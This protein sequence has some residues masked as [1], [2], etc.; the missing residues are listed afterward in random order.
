MKKKIFLK[1]KKARKRNKKTKKNLKSKR[2]KRTS[3]KKKSPRNKMI[4]KRRLIKSVKARKIP[5]RSVRKKSARVIESKKGKSS[6]AYVGKGILEQLFESYLKVRILRFFFRNCGEVF[7]I[8]EIFRRIR[9]KNF[10]VRREIN[11]LDK[12]GLLRRKK[13]WI[14]IK[15]R[16]GRVKKEQRIVYFLNNDF[17]FFNELKNLFLKSA[18][19]SKQDLTERVRRLGN[20]KILLLAGVFT[21]DENAKA[22]IL[23]VGDK[24]NSKKTN[25]FLKD[26]E[27]E[28]GKELNCV[29][30]STREFNY[31]YDMYD[32][33][34]RDL[35]TGKSE[36]LI[37]KINLW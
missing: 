27:A 9:S 5:R 20:I 33:F 17:D 14:E 3:V 29:V 6:H 16:G 37:N 34:V 31:R 35:L 21:G 18:I 12:L 28:V 36:I 26:L 7:P 1:N 25:T 32:R 8:K 22:D 11:K 24:I 19:S 15:G 30:M 10:L 2:R 23:I 13:G 4:K